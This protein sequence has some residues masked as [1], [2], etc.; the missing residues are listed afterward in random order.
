LN[1]ISPNTP[2]EIPSQG[3][4]LGVDW[5]QKRIGLA[6]CNPEQTIAVATEYLINDLKAKKNSVINDFSDLCSEYQI[7]GIVY[8]QPKHLNSNDSKSQN[9]VQNFATQIF[10]IT[11]LPYIFIDER[12]T[13][14]QASNNLKNFLTSKEQKNF[15]DS[16]SARIILQT[17]LDSRSS[18]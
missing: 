14:V 4:L 12:L 10:Q 5:G 9:Q 7:Q 1:S 8:G 11:K 13:T 17:F 3:I 6:I 18:T 16:E 15:I 2:S